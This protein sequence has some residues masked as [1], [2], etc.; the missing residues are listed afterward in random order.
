MAKAADLVSATVWTH[1]YKYVEDV[2]ALH[3]IATEISVRRVSRLPSRLVSAVVMES[4][5]SRETLSTSCQFK[6]SVYYPIPDAML[7]ELRYRFEDK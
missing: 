4:T 2:A 1:L 5:G 6:I 7:S 3:N